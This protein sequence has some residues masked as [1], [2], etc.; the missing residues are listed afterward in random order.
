MNDEEIKKTASG[1]LGAIALVVIITIVAAVVMSVEDYNASK[2]SS[3]EAIN[4]KDVNYKLERSVTK[5]I[6]LGKDRLYFWVTLR[7]TNNGKERKHIS[8]QMVVLYDN[9]G[10]KYE[11]T[12]SVYSYINPNLSDVHAFVYIIPRNAKGLKAEIDDWDGKGYLIISD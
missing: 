2:N 9:T 7:I 1:W 3:R 10:A 12:N 4:I 11:A 5:G 8:D 6:P